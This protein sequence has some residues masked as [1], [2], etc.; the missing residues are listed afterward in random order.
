MTIQDGI[1]AGSLI[2]IAIAVAVVA[3]LPSKKPT[4][5]GAVSVT[6]PVQTQIPVAPV[7]HAQIPVKPS[8]PVPQFHDVYIEPYQPTYNPPPQPQYNTWQYHDSP[9]QP[10]EGYYGP[11][12]T[13][14]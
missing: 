1:I 13:F 9:Q 8:P 14:N 7:Q 6:P 10:P 11:G 12:W 4:Y 3:K 5:S 2:T